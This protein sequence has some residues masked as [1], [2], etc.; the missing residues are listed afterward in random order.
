MRAFGVILSG[1]AAF[2]MWF[3]FL[4]DSIVAQDAKDEK[5]TEEKKTEEKKTEEKKIEKKVRLADPT[6]VNRAKKKVA[7][8]KEC[9][10][11]EPA[12]ITVIPLN[13][14]KYEEYKEWDLKQLNDIRGTAD[15][16]AKKEKFTKYEAAAPAEFDKAFVGDEIHVPVTE[17]VRVRTAFLPKSYDENNKEKK[18]TGSQI[19]ALKTPSLPGYVSSVASL[20]VGQV[21]E[22]YLKPLPPAP[23]VPQTTVAKKSPIGADP[24]DTGPIVPTKIEVYMIYVKQDPQ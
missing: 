4:D 8:I 14:A 5:K 21:V 22:L 19:S 7:K 6:E 1:F 12:E 23:K 3:V 11:A 17:Q 13:Q 16:K 9:K 15:R 18:L 20:K 2:A 10:N 24:K